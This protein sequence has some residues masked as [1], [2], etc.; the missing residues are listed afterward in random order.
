MAWFAELA[1]AFDMVWELTCQKH[2]TKVNSDS[3]P[4]T[5]PPLLQTGSQDSRVLCSNILLSRWK[6]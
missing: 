5:P 1:K 4:C 3:E 6:D 2:K